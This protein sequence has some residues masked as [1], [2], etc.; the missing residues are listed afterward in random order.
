[1]I[2][3]MIMLKCF[4][5]SRSKIKWILWFCFIRRISIHCINHC[6]NH[7]LTLHRMWINRQVVW[8]NRKKKDND[9]C[10]MIVL[11]VQI[12]IPQF[13]S[14]CPNNIT[15]F[16]TAQVSFPDKYLKSKAD[17]KAIN[18][19]K[20]SLTMKKFPYTHFYALFPHPGTSL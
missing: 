4:I 2:M 5:I 6:V 17:H 20:H 3:L 8:M 12:I 7:L 13:Y 15:W 11:N 16:R 18:N 10:L 9:A 14:I 19:S 1:M